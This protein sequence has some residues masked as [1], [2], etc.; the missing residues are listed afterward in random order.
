MLGIFP[1]DHVAWTVDFARKAMV[2]SAAIDKMPGVKGKELWITGTVDP[3]VRKALES[4][5]WKVEDNFG[6]GLLKGQWQRHR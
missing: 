4:R 5:G 2:V 6:E 3:V 1:L